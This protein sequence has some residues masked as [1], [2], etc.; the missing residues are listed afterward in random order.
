MH[1]ETPGGTA[2]ASHADMMSKMLGLTE[3]ILKTN[4]C[5]QTQPVDL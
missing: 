4:E 3:V 1:N 5:R 2:K